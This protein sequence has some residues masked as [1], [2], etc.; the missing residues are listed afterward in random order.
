MY[1]RLDSEDKKEINTR[2]I[3]IWTYNKRDFL[4]Y[5]YRINPRRVDMPLKSNNRF[6]VCFFID[7]INSS[8]IILSLFLSFQDS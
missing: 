2:K 5:K 6:F 1:V 7:H 4:A 8:Y 3:E